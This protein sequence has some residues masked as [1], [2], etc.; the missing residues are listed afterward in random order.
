MKLLLAAFPPELAGLDTT[1]PCGWRVAAVGV[2]AVAAAAGAARLLGE[3]SFERVLFLGTCGAYGEGR[4]IGDLVAAAEVLATSLEEARGGACRPGIE[5]ARWAPGWALPLPAV[6]VAATP[7]VTRTAEG[8][9]ALSALAEVE[10]LELSGVFEACAQA[11]LPCA[12][13]LAVVNRV[14]PEAHQE[15]KENHARVSRALVRALR[16]AGVL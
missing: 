8:A 11:G 12:A 14:G 10:H 16:A 2:G 4:P 7:A 13:A 5:R 6:A 15:W 9:R 3:A 1:P